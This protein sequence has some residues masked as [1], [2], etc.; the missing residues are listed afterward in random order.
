[1]TT[2]V[3]QLIP[4]APETGISCGTISAERSALK[5][6][7]FRE[8]GMERYMGPKLGSARSIPLC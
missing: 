2:G 1:M 8:S 3:R 4:A 6:N 5:L 7:D